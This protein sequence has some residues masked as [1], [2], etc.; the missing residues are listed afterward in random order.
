M[1]NMLF[2][3]FRPVLDP[4]S[5]GTTS[6]THQKS[7]IAIAVPRDYDNTMLFFPL[8]STMTHM[9]CTVTMMLPP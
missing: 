3:A 9:L 8:I 4:H 5:V 7:M 1:Y 2:A 6:K